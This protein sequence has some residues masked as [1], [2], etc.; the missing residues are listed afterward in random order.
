[1]VLQLGMEPGPLH[2]AKVLSTGLLGKTQEHFN[3]MEMICCYY[4]SND[5]TIWI[6]KHAPKRVN[7]IACNID[8]KKLTSKK[9]N[10]VKYGKSKISCRT[11]PVTLQHHTKQFSLLQSLKMRPILQLSFLQLKS[12][13]LCN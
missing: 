3:V 13:N 1:M 10:F 11:F 5:V 2:W 12:H 6:C 4:Y 7:F 8:L 9:L